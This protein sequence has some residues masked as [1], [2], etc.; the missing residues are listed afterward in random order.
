MS[1][2]CTRGTLK[3]ADTGQPLGSATVNLFKWPPPSVAGSTNPTWAWP[4]SAGPTPDY[5]APTYNS[6]E[7]GFNWALD[8]ISGDCQPPEDVMVDSGWWYRFKIERS[9]Y[10]PIFRYILHDNYSESCQQWNCNQNAWVAGS[11]KSFDTMEMYASNAPKHDE[12]PDIFVDPRDLEDH[13]FQCVQM[14][15]AYNPTG[16]KVDL[17]GLRASTGT[18]NVGS[19]K[20]HLSEQSPGSVSQFIEQSDGT[21]RTIGLPFVSFEFHPG[22]SHFHIEDWAQLRVVDDSP[23]CSDPPGVRPGWCEIAQGDKLSF[24]AIDLEKFDDEIAN[25]YGPGGVTAFNSCSDPTNQ[26]I[27]AGYKDVYGKHLLGQVVILGHPTSSMPA[28]GDYFLEGEWDPNGGFV[29]AELDKSNNRAQV[30]IF[31]PSFTTASSQTHNPNC[32]EILNCI[33]GFTA[34]D[35]CEDYLRCESNADCSDGLT[36]QQ[37]PLDATEMFCQI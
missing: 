23:S 25:Y 6:T 29:A 14:P 17:V 22:H 1:I 2:S 11:C 28:T 34:D 36:C 19:G 13:E 15:S 33:N 16:T 4:A 26:G 5:S 30:P 10:E 27:S 35:H 8:D 7:N 24:C 37:N 31:I 18:A 12:L 21:D 32:D 20:F 3:D 9:G